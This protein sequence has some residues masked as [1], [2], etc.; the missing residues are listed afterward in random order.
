MEA[1][2]FYFL[3]IDNEFAATSQDIEHTDD[4]DAEQTGQRLLAGQ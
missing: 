4:M 3:S 1:Y 2:R